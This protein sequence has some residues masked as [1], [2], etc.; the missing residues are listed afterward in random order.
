MV[1]RFNALPYP[2]GAD[3]QP[4]GRMILMRHADYIK[5][6]HTAVNSKDFKMETL[7]Q[8]EIDFIVSMDN[9]DE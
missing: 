3:D 9:G 6:V 8:P 4:L 5:N 1:D 2:G 7:S